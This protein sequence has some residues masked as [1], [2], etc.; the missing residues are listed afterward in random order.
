MIKRCV[1]HRAYNSTARI[2]GGG[3]AYVCGLD[4]YEDDILQLDVL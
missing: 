3:R 2:R 4:T 1:G